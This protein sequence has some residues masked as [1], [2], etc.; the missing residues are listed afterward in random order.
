MQFCRWWGCWG[1]GELGALCGP[2][3]HRQRASA[4]LAQGFVH[5][6]HCAGEGSV[7]PRGPILLFSSGSH[8]PLCSRPY[9][10][11]PCVLPLIC[12]RPGQN[13][14]SVGPEPKTAFREMLDV[15]ALTGR[16]DCLTQ[17]DPHPDDRGEGSEVQGDWVTCPRTTQ[18]ERELGH[19]PGSLTPQ[20]VPLTLTLHSLL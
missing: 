16:R 6:S 15:R 17:S 18:G 9:K 13:S 4:S 11:L 1:R 14:P 7:A 5:A 19:E 10:H 20:P 12:S 2:E 3:G 8:G